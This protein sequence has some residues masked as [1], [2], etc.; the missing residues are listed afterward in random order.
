MHYLLDK[1]K[2][3]RIF[4]TKRDKV[5]EGC[6]KLHNENFIICTL[7]QILLVPD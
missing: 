2:L 6:R 3:R 4:G 1:M 7:H 5:T